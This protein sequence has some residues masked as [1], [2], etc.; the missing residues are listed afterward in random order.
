MD[1]TQTYDVASEMIS[2]FS[3][4][5]YSRALDKA[6]IDERLQEITSHRFGTRIVPS[7]KPCNVTQ[8]KEVQSPLHGHIRKQPR[9]KRYR[10]ESLE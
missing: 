1:A 7:F 4:P 5:S 10:S 6:Q 3:D 8:E 9:G 2:K